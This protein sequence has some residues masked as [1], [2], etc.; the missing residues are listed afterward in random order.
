MADAE[1]PHIRRRSGSTLS[2]TLVDRIT[3]RIQ[4]G[5]YQPGERLIEIELARDFGVSRGSIREALR[6]LEANHYVRFEPNRGAMVACPNLDEVIAMLRIRSVI[7]G[8]GARMAAE[9]IG[10][11][12]NHAKVAALIPAIDHE[13][14]HGSAGQHRDENLGFHQVLNAV[15]GTDYIGELISTVSI[16]MLYDI[17]FRELSDDQWRTNL[18]D[19][20]DL[21]RAVLAGD[22]DAAELFAKRH[23]LR[24]MDIAH[25]ISKRWLS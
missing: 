7:A 23:M 24:M 14:E 16:P 20:R 1:A 11:A 15:S 25:A 12:G 10:L 22:G 5:F 2:S 18:E 4:H 13:L 6:R 9:R 21:A 3:D 17:Y 19:H 8:L